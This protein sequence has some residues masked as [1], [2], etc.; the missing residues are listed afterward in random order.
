MNK[1]EQEESFYCFQTKTF[2]NIDSC[3]ADQA[4]IDLEDKVKA[5]NSLLNRFLRDS[6]VSLPL[7]I[8]S[9][10]LSIQTVDKVIDS[11]PYQG[12]G[13]L[14]S[15]V[16]GIAGLTILTLGSAFATIGVWD[17]A[18]KVSESIDK[19]SIDDLVTP[20]QLR[21][22]E[23]IPCEITDPCWNYFVNE[24]SDGR[25]K[26]FLGLKEEQTKHNGKRVLP[27]NNL[28]GDM[29]VNMGD[30]TYA[31][32]NQYVFVKGAL[33]TGCESQDY[34]KVVDLKTGNVLEAEKSH[35]TKLNITTKGRYN[36]LYHVNAY[37]ET[38]KV[39]ENDEISQEE[40]LKQDRS[41]LGKELWLL[42]KY[43]KDEIRVVDYGPAIVESQKRD[44]ILELARL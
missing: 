13:D 25:Y 16:L 4:E 14:A 7:G 18:K 42:C 17:D 44:A 22:K 39:D 3:L 24:E 27:I 19:L 28:R 21:K 23:L 38:P 29:Q 40:L 12:I 41:L 35:R 26:L 30:G 1:E 15:D 20:N 36:H 10:Y 37:L 9:T 11:I 43:E 6:I 33:I 34:S 2:G 32:W 8:L 31:T 5:T